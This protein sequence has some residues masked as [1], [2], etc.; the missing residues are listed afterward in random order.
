MVE[1]VPMI[2]CIGPV[3]AW[4]PYFFKCM[5]VSFIKSA[6]I[7]ALMTFLEWENDEKVVYLQAYA[8][9]AAELDDLL[10]EEKVS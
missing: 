8:L 7:V 1:C 10:C 2:A 3:L 5:F 4:K 9:A 6:A